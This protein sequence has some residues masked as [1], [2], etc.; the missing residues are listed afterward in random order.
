VPE[1]PPLDHPAVEYA[2]RHG[3]LYPVIT[4]DTPRCLTPP[5]APTP[6]QQAGAGRF[7]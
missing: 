7:V 3:R 2:L 6:G 1:L 5:P 4:G